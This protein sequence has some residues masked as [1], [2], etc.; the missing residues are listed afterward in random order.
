MTSPFATVD[1]MTYQSQVTPKPKARISTAKP[2]EKKKS[3]L[4]PPNMPIASGAVQPVTQPS[5]KPN[6]KPPSIKNFLAGDDIYQQSLRG[7]QRSLSD[8]LSDLTRREG[9]AKTS[10]GQTEGLLEQDRD[11]QLQRMRDEFASRGLL[12][13]GLFAQER[14]EFEEDFGSQLQMMQQNLTMLLADLASQETGFKREQE[15]TAEQARQQALNRRASRF[16]LA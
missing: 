9:E 3:V 14:G 13:S 6:P 4:P 2:P 16:N 8:F 11:R 15:L 7:G 10:F 12:H 5:P 1:G